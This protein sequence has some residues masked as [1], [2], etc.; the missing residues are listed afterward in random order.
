MN[1][2]GLGMMTVA[3]PL[4]II[5]GLA[6]ACAAHHY[7]DEQSPR[8]CPDGRLAGQSSGYRAV[9]LKADSDGG[10]N[11][12][13][14]PKRV[15]EGLENKLPIRSGRQMAEAAFEEPQPIES[16]KP[17]VEL[18]EPPVAASGKNQPTLAPPLRLRPRSGGQVIEIRVE[19]EQAPAERTQKQPASH[20][21]IKPSPGSCGS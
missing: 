5:V 1:R 11:G 19:A 4:G 15:P 8:P 16:P 10:P 20:P 18:E 13:I 2:T 3:V 14:R 6:A 9:A 12:I 7:L 21:R 17:A